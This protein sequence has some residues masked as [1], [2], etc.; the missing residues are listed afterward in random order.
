VLGHEDATTTLSVYAHLFD[1]ER[2]DDAVR[3]AL[4]SM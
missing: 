2:T 1:R 4:A 3:A